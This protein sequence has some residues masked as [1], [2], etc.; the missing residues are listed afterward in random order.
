[1]CCLMYE[2]DTYVEARRRFPR[3]GKT[4]RTGRG[5]EKVVA[6][7]IFKETITLRD[8]EGNRRSVSISEL[9]RE[10]AERSSN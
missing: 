2:H 9:K 1:M 5:S 4:L 6:L 8:G 10:M 7:D 3:E